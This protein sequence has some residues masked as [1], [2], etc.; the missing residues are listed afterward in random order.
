M[1]YYWFE[2]ANECLGMVSNITF[3]M[4]EKSQFPTKFE[5]LDHLF[6]VEILFK[7]TRNTNPF[8]WIYDWFLE[9]QWCNIVEFVN[10]HVS[11]FWNFWFHVFH[12]LEFAIWK[13]GKLQLWNFGISRRWNP[14]TNKN[15]KPRNFETLGIWGIWELRNFGKYLIPL[16]YNR[17]IHEISIING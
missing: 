15:K 8:V 5:T 10:V 2:M 11:C 14:Q 12:F 3:S 6:I 17:I 16:I 13:F 7:N 4:F 1:V 9:S